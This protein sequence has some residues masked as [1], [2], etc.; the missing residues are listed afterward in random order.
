MRAGNQIGGLF[1]K[2]LKLLG[3]LSFICIVM[4]MI[5]MSTEVVMR[6]FFNRPL[7]W[8]VELST[9]L[10]VYI[11]FL[12]APYVLLQNKHVMMDI[13]Y[14]KLPVNTRCWLDLI[15][16]ILM[17][18]VSSIIT[19]YS[20]KVTMDLFQSGMLV[21]GTLEI[22]KYIIVGVMFIS[23][24][25]LVV[26]SIRRTVRHCHHLLEIRKSNI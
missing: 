23:G 13:V 15:S 1:D 20:Y 24:L 2:I 5:I 12:A 22:P 18:F 26:E 4:T 10:L 9:Y 14:A 3:I 16:S 7:G 21:H 25:L 17:I 11:C 6:Y 19:W 8:A